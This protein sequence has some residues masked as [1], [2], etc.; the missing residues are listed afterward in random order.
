MTEK[1]IKNIAFKA[2][3]KKFISVVVAY[4]LGSVGMWISLGTVV[5]VNDTSYS[6]TVFRI[7]MALVVVKWISAFWA[8][9]VIKD[10]M[11]NLVYKLV[12]EDERN[13][14]I[15]RDRCLTK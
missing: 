7:I 6:D 1:E 11:N 12:R 8:F 5:C 15:R 4:L 2:Y 13:H 9:G 3:K 10:G 14:N